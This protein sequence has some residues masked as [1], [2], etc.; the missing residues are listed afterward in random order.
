MKLILFLLFISIISCKHGCIFQ[1]HDGNNCIILEQN[2]C[3]KYNSSE[4]FNTITCTNQKLEFIETVFK[5]GHVFDTNCNLNYYEDV[6]CT[7]FKGKN[8]FYYKEKRGIIPTCD[9]HPLGDPEYLIDCYSIIGSH[10]YLEIYFAIYFGIYFIIFY[11]IVSI[12]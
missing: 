3:F 1:Q 5:N 6:N 7:I 11:A 8:K 10:N 12:F 4:F 2:V 9:N